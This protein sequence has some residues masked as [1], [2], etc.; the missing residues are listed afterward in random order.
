MNMEPTLL[1]ALVEPFIDFGFMRRALVAS[2]CLALSYGALG[3]F[4]VVR[5]LSLVGDAMA[6]ASLPG[7]AAGFL[8]AGLSFPAMTLGGLVAG[9]MVALGAGIITRHTP[10][11]E[12]ASFAALYLTST[13]IGVL[14]LSMNRTHIDLMHLLFGAILAVD[15]HALLLVAVVATVSLLTWRSAFAIWSRSASIR[16][17]WHRSA[18][19]ATSCIW[20]S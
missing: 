5:R 7:I 10:Q 14:L 9:M 11:R 4:L 15:A 12:D 8:V 6:H 17:T 19:A 18:D 20:P 16:N 2:C 3:P 1:R 13:A